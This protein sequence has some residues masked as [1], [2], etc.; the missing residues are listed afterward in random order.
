MTITSTILLVTKK[1]ESVPSGG[2][3]LLCKMNFNA[4]KDLYA[5]RLVLFEL[6]PKRLQGLRAYIN[7]FRG[8]IDGLNTEST[9]SALRVIVEN[10]VKKVFIDGSNLGGFVSELKRRH[11]KVEVTVFFHNVEARFFWGS[12]RVR[13]NI[14]A[15]AVLLANYLAERKAV[16][17][18]DKIICLSER[19]SRTLKRLYGRHATHISPMALED[20]LPATFVVDTL[21]VPESFA[22]FVGGNFYAN[23][24]GIAWFVREV[25][26]EI[27]LPIF[28]VGRGFETM[29]AELEVP[30][31]VIVVGAV[32]SLAD[33][34]RRAQFVI[35]PIFDGSGMKTKVAE[36]LMYGKKIVGTSE[37]YSGYEAVASQ[38]G[39]MCVTADDFVKAIQV[40]AAEI[41]QS[42]YPDLR[43]LYEQHYSM[44]AGR[45]RLKAVL[46]DKVDDY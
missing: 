7:S 16:Q 5:D 43:R 19:D 36:A 25:V 26:P 12:L 14:R 17:C 11:P 44:D 27:G 6:E 1:L 32:D 18:S 38:A 28:I 45:D 20:K 33:W 4:L 9:D 8:H 42:F 2:R 29:R 21:A 24:A 13:R 3:E 39:Y 31:K 37:A 34:Y 23:Q 15:I 22:L 40:A 41:S 35:A 10:N 46:D 30:G